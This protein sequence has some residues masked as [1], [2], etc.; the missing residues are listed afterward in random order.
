MIG[1][2]FCM[3]WHNPQFVFEQ[4]T[5]NIHLVSCTFISATM[6]YWSAHP[7]VALVTIEKLLNYSILTPETVINWALV[8]FTCP[9]DIDGHKHQPE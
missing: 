1:C 6:A 5:P 9:M 7:G 2:G 3:R 8:M 4:E